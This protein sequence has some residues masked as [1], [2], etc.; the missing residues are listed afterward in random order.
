MPARRFSLSLLPKAATMKKTLPWMTVLALCGALLAAPVAWAQ[1][2][3]A[4]LKGEVLEVQNVPGYTYLRLKTVAGESW[5]A[6]PTAAVKPGASVLIVN[7]MVM[8]NFQSKALNRQFDRIVF[9]AL[10]EGKANKAQAVPGTTA[11]PAMPMRPAAA[12]APAVAKLTK[13][14][15]PEGRSVAEV[16][17]GRAALKDKTVLVRGQVVKVNSGIMGKNWLHLQD[18]S[19]TAQEGSHDVLVTTTELAKVGDV[20]QVRGTVRTDV[21]VG[22]GYQYAVLIEGASLR[23]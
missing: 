23:K 22:P 16:V 2:P 14:S 7:T 18:G 19:G 21:T 9:G 17:Q 5:A 4:P 15:G 1:G 20:I 10:D 3:A 13:A 11:M 12:A 8:Q 6:V